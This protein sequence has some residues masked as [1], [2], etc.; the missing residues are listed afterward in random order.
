VKARSAWSA[1]VVLAGMDAGGAHA[2][3]LQ[4]RH[5]VLHQG[6]QR[7]DDDGGARPQQGR[8]L[9]AQRLAAARG[10]QHQGVAAGRDVLDDLRLPAAEGGI[11]EGVVEDG[12][13]G[14]EGIIV[15]V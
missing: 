6:D 5:L 2:G 9:V 10:H 1:S 14:H 7:R 11:A 3:F 13:G 12:E 8:D 15:R 4:R